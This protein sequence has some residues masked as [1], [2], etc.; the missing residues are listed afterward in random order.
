MSRGILNEKV[1]PPVSLQLTINTSKGIVTATLIYCNPSSEDVFIEKVNGCIN[2]TIRNN[3]F[4]ILSEVDK[5]PY[6]GLY[7]KRKDPGPD[8]FY[9]LAPGASYSVTVP[10][11]DA[12]GFF[13]GWHAYRV[14]YVASH[15]RIDRPGEL[16][17]LASTECR[18]S[19]AK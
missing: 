1:M 4:R 5:V 2:G 14:R 8:G 17:E 18:F 10:L 11:S 19:Y 15:P 3:V 9:R 13:P 16:W 7:A 6:L 12:Y